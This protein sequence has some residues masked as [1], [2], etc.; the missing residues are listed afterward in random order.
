MSRPFV[1]R[2]AARAAM[3]GG[4]MNLV[5]SLTHLSGRARVAAPGSIVLMMLGVVGLYVVLG[6]RGG[7]LR[8]MGLAFLAAGLILGVSGALGSALGALGVLLPNPITSVINT[9]EHAGLVLIA[10]G[11]LTWGVL[12]IRTRALG[13]WSVLPLGIGLV[14]V[15]SIVFVLP[16]AF[17]AAEASVLPLVFAASWMLLGLALLTARRAAFEESTRPVLQ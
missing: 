13:H 5:G 7:R 4:A 1:I 8:Q 17:A 6:D 9:G 15:P 12:A 14:S 2:I 11:F 3:L 10:A 16:S